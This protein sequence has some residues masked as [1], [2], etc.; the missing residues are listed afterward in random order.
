MYASRT[1]YIVLWRV[2]LEISTLLKTFVGESFA[3]VQ[4][5]SVQLTIGPSVLSVAHHRVIV[6][7]RQTLYMQSALL[8]MYTASAI[9]GLALQAESD[10]AYR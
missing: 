7:H 1:T 8:P 4:Y 3:R 5:R 9:D 6:A 10:D 2:I